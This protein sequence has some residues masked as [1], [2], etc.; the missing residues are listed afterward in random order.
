MEG[1]IN[2]RRG[3]REDQKILWYLLSSIVWDF[4]FTLLLALQEGEDTNTCKSCVVFRDVNGLVLSEAAHHTLHNIL[5][6]CLHAP[7]NKSSSNR[8]FFFCLYNLKVIFFLIFII[9]ILIFFNPYNLKMIF[10]IFILYILIFLV[11]LIKI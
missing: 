1:R 10:L 4:Y 6:I 9:Y 3:K 8:L 5:C 11:I 2:R 7:S